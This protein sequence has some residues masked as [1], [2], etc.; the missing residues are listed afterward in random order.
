M[1]LW[2]TARPRFN[3]YVPDGLGRD[4]YIGY[5]NGG[6]WKTNEYSISRKADYEYPRY[7]NFH[8]LFHMAAPFKYYSD[9]AG[10]DSYILRG[11]G[12]S[13]DEKPLASY[14]LTDFLRTSNGP[15]KH[16]GPFALSQAEI[17]FNKRLKSL[18]NRM[19]KRLYSQPLK[20]IL[21]KKKV[22]EEKM[23]DDGVKDVNFRES[24]NFDNYDKNL[25]KNETLEN[26]NDVNLALGKS[27][28]VEKYEIED[29]KSMIHKGNH[30]YLKTHYNFNKRYQ[31]DAKPKGLKRVKVSK[32]EINV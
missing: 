31:L 13:H 5:N 10:R 15:F 30:A 1:S 22:T 12:L 14:K 23:K 20:K 7:S 19:I 6:F 24:E 2:R 8:T 26:D 32:I 17:R 25:E 18:E 11:T 27:K 21:D 3:L 28:K 16:K 9:G 4:R 29:E